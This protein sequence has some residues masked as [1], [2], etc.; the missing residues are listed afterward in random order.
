MNIEYVWIPEQCKT[1][2][3]ALFFAIQ[4][5]YGY[6]LSKEKYAALFYKKIYEM[7][8]PD[9]GLLEDM[10]LYFPSLSSVSVDDIENYDM[11]KDYLT[12]L[13][14]EA[15]EFY[16]GYPPITNDEIECFNLNNPLKEVEGALDIEKIKDELENGDFNIYSIFEFVKEKMNSFSSDNSE[17]S[18]DRSLSKTLM[19]LK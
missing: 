12:W 14:L 5:T 13:I 7:V 18:Y 4:T 16:Y 2:E 11:Q 17:Y 10:L 1:T 9:D 8:E 19:G 3:E 6:S 15:K